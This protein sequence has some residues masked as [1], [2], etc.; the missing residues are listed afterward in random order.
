MTEKELSRYYYLKKE[1]SDL[2]ERIIKL[3]YGVGSVEISDMP[4]GVPS[5]NTIQQRVVELREKYIEARV[6]ALEEYLKIE[7]YISSVDDSEIRTMM[8]LRFL[9]LKS[10]EEIG[11]EY[12]YDRTTVSKK[13]RRYIKQVSHNSHQ[14]VLL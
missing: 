5:N 3:G 6:S 4:K 12:H 7:K 8:R 2:E 11:R 1:I 13:I 9:D 10:W 14:N